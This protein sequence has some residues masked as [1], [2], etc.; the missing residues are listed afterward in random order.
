MIGRLS[1]WPSSTVRGWSRARGVPRAPRAPLVHG[2]DDASRSGSA[3]VEQEGNIVLEQVR[4]LFGVLAVASFVA[5]NFARVKA[6]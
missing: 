3:P 4:I 2:R 6:V 5:A 1:G